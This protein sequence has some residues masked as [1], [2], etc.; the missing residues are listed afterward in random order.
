M[1]HTSTPSSTASRVLTYAWPGAVLLAFLLPLRAGFTDDGFIHIRYA[2][3]LI[4]NGTYSFN[5]GEVSFGTTS[6]LWVAMLAAIGRV[7]G[8]GE[9]LVDAS[10]VLSW[11]AAFASL[12]AA[13]ALARALGAGRLV[14]AAAAATLAGDV[15]FARWSALGMETALA[16]FAVLAMA[17]ASTRAHDDRRAAAML[18]FFIAIASLVRPEVYLALPVFIVAAL[19]SRSDRRCAFVTIAVA[20]ALLVPWLLFA[21][22]HIGSFLPNTAGAKSGGLVLDPVT[23]VRKFTPIAKIVL[24][25]QGVALLGVMALVAARGIRLRVARNV[26]FLALWVVALPV[27]YVVFDIQVLSRYVLLVTPVL[28]VAGIAAFDRLPIERRRRR[29]VVV[30]AT[31]VSIA[32]NAGFHARVV[33]PASRAFSHDL[34]HNLRDLALYLRDHSPPDAVVAAADIGYL[35]FY[36]QRRVL[37]LG[38]LVEPAMLARRE[39]HTYEEIMDRAMY[40]DVPGYPHVDYVIDRVT[41]PPRF[42]GVVMSGHRFERVYATTVR[43]LGIRKPGPYHYALYRTIPTEP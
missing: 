25:S 26:R 39:A 41:E 34:T 9:V 21:R 17:T 19:W 38:G 30:A 13:Y 15:W 7:L 37:D 42:D 36:S 4:T 32:V 2:Q 6:P 5:P 24:S 14:A 20:A 28:A 10:R 18:G 29:A 33:L 43:N 11:L 40:F 27:A 3:N 16:V 1:N 35:S 12:G 8:S 31:L 23:F 22:I